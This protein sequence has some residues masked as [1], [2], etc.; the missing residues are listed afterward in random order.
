MFTVNWTKFKILYGSLIIII[1]CVLLISNFV[2]NFTNANEK[3]DTRVYERSNALNFKITLSLDKFFQEEFNDTSRFIM[4]L[5]NIHGN[6]HLPPR[7]L[8]MLES[9]AK[10]HSNTSISVFMTSSSVRLTP[11]VKKLLNNYKNV[12]IFHLNTTQ[13][14]QDIASF[15]NLCLTVSLEQGKRNSEYQF[16]ANGILRYFYKKKILRILDTTYDE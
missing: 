4:T 2:Q 12:K 10:S 11:I 13:L 3:T 14:C 16:Y 5:I 6:K 9:A 1:T 15:E 7:K 8:C